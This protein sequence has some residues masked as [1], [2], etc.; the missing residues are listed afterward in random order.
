MTTIADWQDMIDRCTY[1]PTTRNSTPE[2]I[3]DYLSYRSQMG[4]SLTGTYVRY[5]QF[6]PYINLDNHHIYD[7]L[8]CL[9]QKDNL[10]I[11]IK[12]K[13]KPLISRKSS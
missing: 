1:K 5:E 10:K 7:Y 9:Y 12:E 4:D 11:T 3:E 2:E 6:N 13:M 8:I